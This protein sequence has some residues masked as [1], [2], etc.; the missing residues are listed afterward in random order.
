VR[1]S[2]ALGRK[3]RY[4]TSQEEA[5]FVQQVF[6]VKTGVTAVKGSA[7]QRLACT[8][9]PEQGKLISHVCSSP[10]QDTNALVQNFLNSLSGKNQNQNQ[11]QRQAI[12]KPY[13]T[14]PDLLTTSSTIAFIDGASPTQINN[15]CSL[16][17]PDLFLLNQE[18]SF[19]SSSSDPAPSAAAGQ[20]AIEAQTTEQKKTILKRALRSPQFAQSLGSLTVALRDGGLPMIGE[21]LGL[22]VQNGGLIRGGSMPLGGGA[23]VEA[24]VEGVK[25]TVEE[26]KKKS[27]QE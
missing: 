15:L 4:K 20:A 13:T 17:P 1:Y 7:L 26:E 6:L 8:A 16:L 12:D 3:K 25:R 24:F 14:L 22:K 2:E 27:E 10:Q 21:A 18:S 23:A 11:Q 19:D 9:R 5:G